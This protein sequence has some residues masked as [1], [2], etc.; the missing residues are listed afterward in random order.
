MRRMPNRLD[1][2]AIGV[3]E[4]A[5]RGDLLVKRFGAQPIGGGPGPGYD[6]EQ[7]RFANGARLELIAPS[8][9]P[10]SFMR[11]FIESR[12]P[13]I[14]HVTFKVPDLVAVC[15][16]ARKAGY[17]IVGYSDS[18]PMWREAF[19]HPKQA[20]GIVVQFAQAGGAWKSS[21]NPEPTDAPETSLVALR[22]RARDAPRATEL[23]TQVCGGRETRPGHFRWEESAIEIRVEITDGAA[24][25]PLEIVLDSPG[26]LDLPRDPLPTFGTRFVQDA[27][28]PVRG[29]LVHTRQ[30]EIA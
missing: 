19:L 11:R 22:L 12:G 4:I 3:D 17:E 1:H 9:N 24:E 8:A 29:E 13:G 6:A 2:V 30:R 5:A 26:Q 14:H 25:G 18:N 16:R 15:D 21:R 27:E 28:R 20:Q 7:W 10:A 23:W